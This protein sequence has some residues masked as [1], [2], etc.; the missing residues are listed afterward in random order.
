[1]LAGMKETAADRW[2]V[3]QQA[4]GLPP[5]ILAKAPET[6]WKHDPRAFRAPVEPHDTPSRDAALA[7]LA[8]ERGSGRART[9]L[10][11]GCGGGSASLAVADRADLLVGLDHDPGMLK[12][13]AADA[14]AR[15]VEHRAVLGEW[16]AAAD[17]AGIADVV[18]CHHV[19]YNTVE[20]APFLV[21]LTVAARR[22]VVMEL[23]GQ[24]PMAW[25]DPLWVRFHDFHRETSATAD[26]VVAVLAQLGITPEVTRWERPARLPEDPEWVAKR[27]CLPVERAGEVAEALLDIAPRPRTTVTLTW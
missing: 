6:P 11:V 5:E 4:R 21:G 27:L 24:H 16:P 17:D 2:R 7:L 3:L 9:V 23:T 10:D 12:V 25:L 13:F 1:M 8:P 15:G 19:G 14:A 26:D 18:L 20:I 22:G